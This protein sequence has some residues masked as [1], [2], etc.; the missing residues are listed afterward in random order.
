MRHGVV[1]RQMVR[2]A[3]AQIGR[4]TTMSELAD[5]VAAAVLR[6]LAFVDKDE[7]KRRQLQ[8]VQQRM[9]TKVKCTKCGSAAVVFE[10]QERSSDEGA[11]VYHQCVN[12]ECKFLLRIA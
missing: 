1:Y 10:K 9:K 6:P 5:N 3:L 2:E 11:T 12:P 4:L 8:S 7:V